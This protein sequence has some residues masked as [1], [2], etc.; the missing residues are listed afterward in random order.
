MI[1]VLRSKNLQRIVNGEFKKH[2]DVKY[3]AK[4]EEIYDQERGPISKMVSDSL[5]V[6]I[7][8]E[9]NLVEVW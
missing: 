5:Q 6:S 1:D 3:V 9:D 4:W 8:A 7:Q 2:V